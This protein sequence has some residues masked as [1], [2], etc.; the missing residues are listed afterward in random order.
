MLVYH[1]RATLIASA[2]RKS[3]R[4]ALETPASDR[5]AQNLFCATLLYQIAFKKGKAL[6]YQVFTVSLLLSS[7]L[8]FWVQPMISKM[9]VPLFGGTP[10]VWT[11]SMLFFQIFLLIGYLYAHV[12]TKKL[13][14]KRQ[15]VIH[16]AVLFVGFLT[17][18]FGV[19]RGEIEPLQG[20]VVPV[21]YQ[22]WLLLVAVG[23]PFFV[24]STSSPLLQK[25]FSNTS[26]ESAKDPY[27]LYA[28]SNFGSLAALIGYPFAVEPYLK[29]GDQTCLWAG[30]YGALCLLFAFCA[31]LIWRSSST[32]QPSNLDLRLK[33]RPTDS[34]VGRDKE[35]DRITTMRR[36]RWLLLSFVPSSLMLGVTSYLTADI[37]SIPLLWTIPLTLYLL[38][39]VLVF[40]RKRILPHWIMLKAFPIAA[41]TI[42]FIT[43]TEID[44]PLWIIF[45]FYLL[46]FFIAALVCHGS[47]ADDRPGANNLTEFYLLLSVG[48]ALGGV[49]NAVLAPLLFNRTIEL[50]LV[51][52]I[53]CLVYRDDIFKN[54]KGI[55]AWLDFLIPICLG[56]F[57]AL[58][59]VLVP[60]FTL[61]PYRFWMIVI[62]GAPLVVS[63]LFVGN[64][65]R[66]GLSL[67]AVLV[68][69]SFFTVING[70]VLF[71]ERN[72]FG[73]VQV[74]VDESGPFHKLFHGTTLH[75]LQF[76]DPKRE[77]EP[78][79]YYH[80]KGPFG[81]IFET[82]MSRPASSSV[83]IVG[84]GVGS[85]LHYATP[86][87]DWTFYEIDPSVIKV[88]KDSRYFSH[89]K[90][91]KARTLKV[92][93][94]DARVRLRHAADK[95]YGI[96]V[97]DAFSSDAIPIHLITREAFNLYLSKL[98]RG[99]VLA[100][101]M[102]NKYM[103]LAPVI[104]DLANQSGLICL[105]KKDGGGEA[106]DESTKGKYPSQWIIMARE[107]KALGKLIYDRRW[108]Y[109]APRQNAEP[110]TDDF[111]NIISVLKWN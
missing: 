92:V 30:A 56:G 23:L 106:D 20:N 1:V 99:G 14:V 11:T 59:A 73:T 63:F 21:L 98:A 69:S 58:A 38:S 65:L 78:L 26:H 75:G 31:V 32:G 77:D 83:G 90:N 104:G 33:K 48:G 64:P 111:S 61:E 53:A 94:G 100:I 36:I 24:V 68:G 18:P 57:T 91:S 85:M 13:S 107:E 28:A 67:G 109:I 45:A 8:L 9:I 101:H 86:K 60:H 95:E 7:M 35:A 40:A 22:S 66:Y 46:F 71:S 25:W 88:A 19:P 96:L 4:L 39:F 27:F 72:Y 50:P 80:V 42:V 49:F 47:L 51:L 12:V 87:Q 17:L 3:R 93:Q 37:A 103:D 10:S 74:R 89:W 43:T 15:A 81:E 44:R 62:F 41:V 102:S 97:I 52:V 5:E 79:S 76:T 108:N 105:Y 2:F 54:K 70:H 110:W 55:S 6:I 84:L 34:V 82:Y 16:L 29:L